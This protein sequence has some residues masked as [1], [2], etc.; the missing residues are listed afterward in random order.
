MIQD[1]EQDLEGIGTSLD[2][3]QS[4]TLLQEAQKKRQKRERTLFLDVPSWNGDLIAE[5][6]VVPP[7]DLRRIAEGA[8]R[9]AR[10]GRPEPAEN[11]ISMIIAS[12]IGLYMKNPEGEGRVALEDEFGIVK[13]D[14]IAGLLGKEDEI[15]DNRTAV[16]YLM[17]ERDE[18]GGWTPNVL[19]ISLHANAIAKWT[20]DPSKNSA[21]VDELLGE[22]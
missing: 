1:H 13:Y 22:L 14:R 5:Y 11:D 8:L 2:S 9:R 17:S 10:N 20:K 21:D 16:R 3:A 4:L 15:K 6:R 19:A 12:C 7:E 18:N